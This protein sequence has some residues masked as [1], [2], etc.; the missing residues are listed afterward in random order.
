VWGENSL[1][2]GAR[3]GALEVLGQQELT[4]ASATSC[5]GSE[6]GLLLCCSHL[7]GKKGNTR[8]QR[9]VLAMNRIFVASAEK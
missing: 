7:R 5:L 2:E 1:A 6:E 9:G 4:S 3:A 8:Y